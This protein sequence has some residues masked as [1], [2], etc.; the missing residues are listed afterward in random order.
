MTDR[1][2]A[3]RYLDYMRASDNW[4]QLLAAYAALLFTLWRIKLKGV[5]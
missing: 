1:E 2:R 3:E 4:L 5:E